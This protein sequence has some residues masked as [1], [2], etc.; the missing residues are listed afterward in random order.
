[1]TDD[2]ANIVKEK[3]KDELVRIVI[4]KEEYKDELVEAATAELKR[5]DKENV[6]GAVDPIQ[7]I[8]SILQA[9]PTVKQQETPFGIF[10][11]GILL[12]LTGPAWLFFR[13]AA[14]S[15]IGHNR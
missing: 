2:F 11:A 12:F 9:G 1:M 8:N 5:R 6:S 3:S 13:S 14:G 15:R 7:Q 10:F 4:N